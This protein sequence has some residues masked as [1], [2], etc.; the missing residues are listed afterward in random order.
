MVKL[1]VAIPSYN[2]EENLKRCLTS[3]KFLKLEQND[4]EIL[5]VDNASTD[6]TIS[7]IK[8]FQSTF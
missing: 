7:I 3:C 1:T 2:N 6:N 8:E 5:I 4:F